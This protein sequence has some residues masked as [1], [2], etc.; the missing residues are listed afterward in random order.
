MGLVIDV[1]LKIAT[2]RVRAASESELPQVEQGGSS[3]HRLVL[4]LG[5]PEGTKEWALY[6]W[7]NHRL[8]SMKR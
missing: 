2:N 6:T 3:A 7:Y 5:I 8:L 1:A 4:L